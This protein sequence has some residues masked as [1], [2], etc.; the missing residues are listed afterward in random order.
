MI[1]DVEIDDAPRIAEIYNHYILNT[2]ITFEEETLTNQQVASRIEQLKDLKMPWIVTEQQGQVVGYAYA[3]KFKERAAYRYATE[4]SVY[5]DH[6]ATGAGLGTKLFTEL[7]VRLEKTPI[8]VV[9]GGIALPNEASIAL[10]EKFGMEKVADFKQ[11]G[12][13]F[14]RWIDVGYWQKVIK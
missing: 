12:Y 2:I 1:R 11:V 10:H 5:L 6:Q 13:K 3:G 9:I 4:V 14:D 8:H 7:F